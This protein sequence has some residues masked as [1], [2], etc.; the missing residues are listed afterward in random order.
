MTVLFLR[1]IRWTA[2]DNFKEQL[3]DKTKS[4]EEAKITRKN[5]KKLLLVCTQGTPFTFNNKMYMQT[6]GVMMGSP[7]G[8][9][10]E[11]IFM[12]EL[13]NTIIPS[14][15][16]KVCQWKRYV[17]DT[18]AFIKPNMEQEI[19]LALNSFH[20]NIK[21]TYELEQDNSISFLDVLITRENDGNMETGVYRKPTHTDV[22]LNWNAH[23]PN[24]WKTSTV[25]SLAKRAFK[26]CSNDISLNTELNHLETVFIN[27]NDYPKRVINNIIKSEKEKTN[28]NDESTNTN[29]EPTNTNT[30]TP[31][32]IITLTLPYA[33][34]IEEKSSTNNSKHQRHQNPN[35]IQHQKTWFK[36]PNQRSDEKR[37]PTR[38]RLPCKMS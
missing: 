8:A 6:D 3:T 12:C 22:Y 18:F 34:H 19:Q 5:L 32:T 36:I 26:V 17:D 4:A 21:F 20:E 35:Y 24:I 15:G 11:N 23:A 2:S 1:R 25:R 38:R 33:G 29:D 16:D 37:T 9:L 30:E 31:P 27:N 13:E 28:T 10:F 7:L 14:L